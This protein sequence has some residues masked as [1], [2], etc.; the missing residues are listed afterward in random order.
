MHRNNFGNVM[1][2]I[3]ISL[4]LFWLHVV[5]LY[6]SVWLRVIRR[7]WWC[8]GPLVTSANYKRI[9]YI[10]SKIIKTILFYHFKSVVS[11]YEVSS[12]LIFCHSRYNYTNCGE[13]TM[14]GWG[15]WLCFAFV[16]NIFPITGVIVVMA[17]FG[18]GA[19][20]VPTESAVWGL[21]WF[22]KF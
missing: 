7:S 19:T 21:D 1:A 13:E 20:F 5:R 9:S 10:E 18:H 8:G 22:E 11:V 4:P 12:I 14:A 17:W 15:A 16:V 6:Y 2:V 3:L